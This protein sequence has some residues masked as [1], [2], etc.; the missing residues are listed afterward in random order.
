MKVRITMEFTPEQVEAIAGDFKVG[1]NRRLG[2]LDF[3][4]QAIHAAIPPAMK[5]YQQQQIIALK[6]QVRRLEAEAQD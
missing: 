1:K 5:L 4:S 2:L 6:E 3:M